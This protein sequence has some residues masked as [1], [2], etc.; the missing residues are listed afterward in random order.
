MKTQSEDTMDGFS[1]TDRRSGFE[2]VR[3]AL[4]NIRMFEILID[5]LREANRR[6]RERK[7]MRARIRLL[8]ELDERTLKDIG[9]ARGELGS[10]SAELDGHT[11][12]TRRRVHKDSVAP[13]Y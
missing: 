11:E 3:E 12:P 10:I 4:R 9:L 5:G 1:A 6:R 2:R 13:L 8:S 7:A